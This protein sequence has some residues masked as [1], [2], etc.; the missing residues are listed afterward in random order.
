MGNKFK[1][2]NQTMTTNEGT[3]NINFMEKMTTKG[4]Q[5]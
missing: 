1:F 5:I 4:R 3:K 2:T